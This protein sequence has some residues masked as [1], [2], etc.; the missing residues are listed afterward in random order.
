MNHR[1]IINT[2]TASI[3]IVI[4]LLLSITITT[5]VT[6]SAG[7]HFNLIEG[8]RRCFLEELPEDQL[9]VGQYNNLD[10]NKLQSILPPDST[11]SNNNQIPIESAPSKSDIVITVTDPTGEVKLQ[12]L[13]IEKGSVGFRSTVAGEHSICI[14]TSTASY[15]G[16]KRS[17][18]FEFSISL[19]ES[20]IDYSEIAKLEHLTAIEIEVRKLNDKIRSIKSEQDYQTS[21]EARFRD[22]SESTNSRVLWFSLLQTIILIAAGLWQLFMLKR[23]FKSKKLA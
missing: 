19:G 13:T 18:R 1:Y 12:Q 10:W 4:L 20:A 7:M 6:V 2:M 9:V 23:F 22:T 11:D 17:F 14:Q 3:T 5:T 15:Y 16:S 21:R 8:N